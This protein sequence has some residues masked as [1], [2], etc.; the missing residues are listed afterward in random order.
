MTDREDVLKE[1]PWCASE[2]VRFITGTQR[3]GR[4]RAVVIANCDCAMAHWFDSD[5]AAIAW[6]NALPRRS[7]LAAALARVEF[8]ECALRLVADEL[9]GVEG[10]SAIRAHDIARRALTPEKVEE[11]R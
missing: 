6:W 10:Y 2:D 3:D 11:T 5:E 9:E 8:L 4:Y 1:C 7:D